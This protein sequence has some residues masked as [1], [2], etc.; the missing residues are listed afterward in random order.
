MLRQLVEAEDI[1]HGLAR[2]SQPCSKFLLGKVLLFHSSLIRFGLVDRIEVLALH[3]L[4]DRDLDTLIPA[5]HNSRNLG[6]AQASE[7]F[8][9]TLAGKQDV[10]LVAA[11]WRLHNSNGVDETKRMDRIRELLEPLRV[12]ALTR[13]V[14]VRC[15]VRNIDLPRFDEV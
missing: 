10:S 8:K 13:L 9:A 11:F 7:G 6:L 14:R 5:L 1:L 2:L 15:D 3:V 12:H 4:S